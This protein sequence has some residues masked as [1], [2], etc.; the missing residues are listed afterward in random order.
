MP[1]QEPLVAYVGMQGEAGVLSFSERGVEERPGRA[2]GP[3][4]TEGVHLLAFSRQGDE[5]LALDTGGRARLL[6][7][8][9]IKGTRPPCP[10]GLLPR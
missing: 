2:S 5:L 7:F 3:G 1:G 4:V 10:P 9:G 8:P 6:A